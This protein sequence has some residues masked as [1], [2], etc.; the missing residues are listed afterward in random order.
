MIYNVDYRNNWRKNMK[1]KVAIL[2]MKSLDRQYQKSTQIVLDKMREA[3]ENGADI[4]L[5]PEVFLTG[6]ECKRQ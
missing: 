2:Q 5:L 6:Y 3:T 1:L 4:L